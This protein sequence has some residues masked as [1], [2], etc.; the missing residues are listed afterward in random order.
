MGAMVVSSQVTRRT[1]RDRLS[2]LLAVILFCAALFR[3][4]EL[5]TR[6]WGIREI[7]GSPLNIALSG[8]LLLVALMTGL[9]ATGTLAIMQEHPLRQS[10]ER[11]LAFSLIT[12]TLGTLL[13]TLWL[14]RAT[15]LPVWLVILL[16]GGAFVG[17]LIQLSYAAFTT[18]NPGYPSARTMLN[19]ANYLIGFALFSLILREQERALVTGPVLFGLSWLL[20]A[21]LLSATGARQGLVIVL[22]T[23]I[24]LIE[25]ELAWIVGY[26]PVSA[27]TTATVLTLGLYLW[28]GIGYQYLLGRL[29]RRIVIEF[30]MTA[31]LILIIA[32][33]IRV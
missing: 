20:A 9:V 3:F 12:P 11:A 28:G 10:K 8:D 7:F 5:P 30:S 26:W 19:I 1:E 15:S 29:T 23:T 21:E 27:W 33:W 31:V 6:Y 4:V 32:L 2:V 18:D 24:A 22:A 16:L 25:S 17:L 14:V 13:M